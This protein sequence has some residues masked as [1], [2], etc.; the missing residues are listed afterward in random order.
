LLQKRLDFERY[1]FG[2]GGGNRPL[3]FAAPA[4]RS[5]ARAFAGGA[6][7]EAPF[8]RSSLGAKAQFDSLIKSRLKRRGARENLCPSSL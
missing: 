4:A 5:E 2:A 7:P 6:S 8:P 3:C 1:L